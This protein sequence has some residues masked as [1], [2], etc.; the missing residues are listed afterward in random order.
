MGE[1]RKLHKKLRQIENLEIKPT[2]TPE[3]RVKISKKEELRARLAELLLQ[4]SAPQQT[5]GIVGDDKEKM[6]RRVSRRGSS[7]GLVSQAAAPKVPKAAPQEERGEEQADAPEG[8]VHDGPASVRS[9]AVG[10]QE[11]A[12]FATLKVA[13]EKAGFRLRPLEGHSDIVTCVLAVDN[14]VVSG[15]RDT[16]I[17]VWH[18]PTATEQRNLGGHSRG[19]TS[20][21]SPPPEYCRRLARL[22]SL[23]ER[24]RFVLSGSEDCCVKVWALS[25]GSC[26]KS[27]YTFN[28]VSALTFISEGDGHIVTG[29]DGGKVEVWSWD[30]MECCQ[31]VKAH[32]DRVTSLQC[33]GPLLFSGSA[34]GA[35]SVWQTLH[36]DPAPLKQLH[37]WSSSV[38]GCEP[39]NGSAFSRLAL[40]PRGDKV[41]LANG[42]ASL[43][44]LDWRTGSVSRLANHSSVAGVTDCVSQ[45]AGI[46][47]ASCFD[48]ATGESSLNLFSLPQCKYLVSLTCPESPRSLCFTA[49]LTAS[50]DHRWVT[51][52]RVL[53]VWEQLPSKKK[54]SGDVT[55]RRD[56]RL[57]VPPVESDGDTDEEESDD[58]SEEDYMSQYA[59]ET[60]GSPVLHG[61]G[62][63]YNDRQFTQL[64]E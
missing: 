49:W 28:P 29:S 62:V 32:Q 27:I 20:L 53:T 56:S 26:V 63:L 39:Q 43:K 10:S 47:I 6:K 55:V 7:D 44:I 36:S 40:S 38:T 52:G 2:L 9:P 54:Q 34:D 11:D 21:S 15:S 64:P 5:Q 4:H 42:K 22:L 51:G 33:Q 19:V 23:G 35:I 57:D 31:S 3:E 45:T 18:V 16:T 17:K 13:W 61:S 8:A 41:F 24:E 25:T 1:V 14:L 59:S 48:L 46:L 30:S 50:G 60:G 37:H 58:Y 12:R